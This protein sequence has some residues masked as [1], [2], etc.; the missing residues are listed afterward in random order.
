MPGVT[1]LGLH[2][3]YQG[4]TVDAASWQTLATDMDTLMTATQALRTQAF[5]PPT[6]SIGN[7]TA[8]PVNTASA[9]SA[10][11]LF[12]RVH[13]DNAS[14]VNLAVNN[15][16][17]T[18]GP[19]VWHVRF[20]ATLQAVTTVTYARV[21]IL[22]TNGVTW[23]FAQM[24]TAAVTIVGG[25]TATAYVVNFAPTLGIEGL[26]SWVGT[27]GPGQWAASG[28]ELQVSRIRAIADA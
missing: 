7:S 25:I 3:P 1:S 15:D 8:I 27:G 26:V 20:T 21:L 5:K 6:A 9:G 22:D 12:D 4:E 17:I 19:G 18:I 13:W 28:S 2:Y 14:L 23:G 10:V 24:D 16:R 11:M